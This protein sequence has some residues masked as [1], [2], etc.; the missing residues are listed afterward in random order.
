MKKFL[1]VVS[2]ILALLLSS[3]N[4]A[5]QLASQTDSVYL[6]IAKVFTK[7]AVQKLF[8]A[9]FTFEKGNVSYQKTF[10]TEQVV[11]ILGKNISN[12][13]T[14]N[15]KANIKTERIDTYISWE[16]SENKDEVTITYKRTRL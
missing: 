15:G 8:D 11:K 13:L 12:I 2:M 3:C 5:N 4:L 7:T 10:K 14:Y 16:S 6:D 9:E 1:F